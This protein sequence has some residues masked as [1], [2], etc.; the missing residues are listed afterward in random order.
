[1]ATT[2]P[3]GGLLKRHC[4]SVQLRSR[5]D[6]LVVRTETSGELFNLFALK[7]LSLSW[8]LLPTER[9]PGFH[10]G[11]LPQT[12]RQRP[13]RP[14]RSAALYPESLVET[15]SAGETDEPQKSA[16]TAD[17]RPGNP[18]VQPRAPYSA[19]IHRS[20]GRSG[21]RRNRRPDVASVCAGSAGET[22]ASGRGE[23]RRRPP[24]HSCHLARERQEV[25]TSP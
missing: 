19:L 18:S 24:R 5:T 12:L 23:T 8:Q 9:R 13:F 6:C 25:P 15:G 10:T 20:V 3:G 4:N 16:S 21:S 22:F 2:A 17:R 1:M 7:L 14:G 11:L